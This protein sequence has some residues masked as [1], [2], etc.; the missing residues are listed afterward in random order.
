[1]WEY[2]CN[3]RKC[4]KSYMINFKDIGFEFYGFNKYFL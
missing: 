3:G 4:G 2:V 1:M